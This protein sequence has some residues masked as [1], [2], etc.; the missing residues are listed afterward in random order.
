MFLEDQKLNEV[1]VTEKEAYLDI[2]IK[3]PELWWPN[4]IGTPYIYDFVVKVMKDKKVV[5]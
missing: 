5:E 4:G 2:S 3:K 1:N